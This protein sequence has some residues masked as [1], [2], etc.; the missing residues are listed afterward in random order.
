MDEDTLNM[1][2][3]RFLKE[4]GVTTQREIE[5]AIRTAIEEETLAGDEDLEATATA[6]VDRLDVDVTVSH[7]IE[8]E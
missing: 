6:R 3:R 4:F 2:V 8:L 5:N 1:E 7:T